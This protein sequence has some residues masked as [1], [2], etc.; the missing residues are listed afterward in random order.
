MPQYHVHSDP[1]HKLLLRTVGAEPG[2]MA[3]HS[4]YRKKEF[5][6]LASAG[7]KRY[8]MVQPAFV[9]VDKTGN[10]KQAWSWMTDELKELKWGDPEDLTPVPSFGGV[11]LVTVRPDAS[12]IW[13]SIKENRKVKLKGKSKGEVAADMLRMAVFNGDTSVLWLAIK[14]NSIKF[15]KENSTLVIVVM[16]AFLG[17][18]LYNFSR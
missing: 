7:Y 11:P 16:V 8:T 13:P 6:S 9:I 17:L 14:R 18:G 2:S 3:E 12:D 4:L 5:D 1:E 10:V 15:F